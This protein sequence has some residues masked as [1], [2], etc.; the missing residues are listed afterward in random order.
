METN[1]NEL[2]A[3]GAN[4]MV[5]GMV[6]VFALLGLMVITM[7]GMSKLAHLL[8]GEPT[9]PEPPAPPPTGKPD[10]QVL[11][12]ISAAIHKYRRSRGK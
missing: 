12:V 7:G 4:L 5:L 10:Q 2:L 3:A 8:A 9:P 1:I 6:V 11:S